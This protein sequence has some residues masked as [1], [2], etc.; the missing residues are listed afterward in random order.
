MRPPAPAI[1]SAST[2]D[3]NRVSVNPTRSVFHGPPNSSTIVT[4]ASTVTGRQLRRIASAS[5]ADV[6]P[7]DQTRVVPHES[8]CAAATP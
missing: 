5:P 7:A 1:G 3:A 2:G 6:A 8:V 4:P